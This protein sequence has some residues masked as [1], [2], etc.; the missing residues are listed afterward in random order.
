VVRKNEL[1]E[2]T[3]SEGADDL[4]LKQNKKPEGSILSRR[5]HICSHAW[6][7]LK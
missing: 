1:H 3:Q 7:S 6:E 2:G 4:R 5:S